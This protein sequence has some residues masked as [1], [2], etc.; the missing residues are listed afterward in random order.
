MADTAKELFEHE[1]RDIY[2]AENKLVR[3]T[4]TMAKKVSDPSLARSFDEH[5][6]VTKQQVRRLEKVFDLVG[7][8]PRRERCKGIDG[9]IEE[10]TDF[11]KEE[12]PS[13]EVLDLFATAAGAK[14]EHYEISAYNSLIQLATQLGI[15][16]G[17]ALLDQTLAEE[18][19][20]LQKLET[21]SKEVGQ[22]LKPG[23]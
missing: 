17:V 19:E 4:E 20:T 16:E 23:F 3:A 13:K 1:L 21:A 9:L 22:K 15:E 12:S 18:T 7:R 6:R 8:K 2:D 11:V 10:F 5:S 14:V